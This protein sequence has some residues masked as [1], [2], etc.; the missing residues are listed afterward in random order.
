MSSSSFF[1]AP[2][3]RR[4]RVLDSGAG[5]PVVVLHGWGGRIESMT[6]VLTCLAPAFRI[7]AIDLPGFGESAVPP[8][9]WG[10]SD[11][12]V[13]V[14]EI[15]D[16]LEVERAHFV[17]HSFG[18]RT[19]MFIA[20]TEP[21]YVERLVLQAPSGLRSPPSL[22]ARLKKAASKGGRLAG[23][24]GPAGRR[25][26]QGIYQRVASDDYQEAGP[27]R[28]VLVR[29]VNEDLSAMLPAVVSSTLLIWGSEDDAVPVEHGRRMEAQIPDAGLIIF[30]GAG[31]F[32]YLEEPDRFCRITR[33]FLN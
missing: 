32:A 19:S 5:H 20:A 27:M 8:P 22:K 9:E 29:V 16:E 28:P 24:L 4:T 17:G 1:L 30:E 11:Y 33:H 21:S 15:L 23:R 25:L 31:H 6:P 2:E 7:V 3:G 12:A 18:A 26:K 14:C 10:T 13:H